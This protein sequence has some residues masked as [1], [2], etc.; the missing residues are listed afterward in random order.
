MQSELLTQ[1]VDRYNEARR[2][3]EALLQNLNNEQANWKPAPDKWSVLECLK[4]VNQAVGT[5]AVHMTQA[6][7]TAKLKGKTGHEPYSK[8]TLIGRIILS[9]MRRGPERMKVRSPRVFRPS[10]GSDEKDNVLQTFDKIMAMLSS[11]AEQSDGMPLGHVRFGT[12]AGPLV[13]V[14]LAQAF[15]IH[16]LHCHRHLD[17][18]ERVINHEQFPK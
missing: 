3:A 11:L 14:S 9:A 7:E 16:A 17:Q 1:C 2:R 4:H 13:R 10:G 18:A 6:I 8:G 12:P 5:Y 15:D